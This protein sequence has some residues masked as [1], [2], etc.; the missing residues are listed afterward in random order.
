MM[1]KSK[2]SNVEC[3]HCN[4]IINGKPWISVNYKKVL[5]MDVLIVVVS[6]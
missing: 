5:F 6:D 3:L 1:T 4:K 2:I